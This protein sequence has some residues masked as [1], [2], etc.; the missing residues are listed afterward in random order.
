[1]GQHFSRASFLVLA[2]SLLGG[3]ATRPI[4]PPIAEVELK[5]GYRYLTH[6]A[7]R[8]NNDSRTL[9]I[10]AFSGGGTRAA[11]F[12]Y[13]V[14]EALR[15][16]EVIGPKGRKIRLLDE[17]DVVTGVSG[18]SFTALA[19]GLYGEKLF[20]LYE[21]SFLKRD[22]QGELV[23]R[24]FNPGNWGALWSEGWGRSEMAAQLYDEILFHGATFADLDRGSGPLVLASATDI[25]TGERLVFQQL[26]F[27]YLCSDLDAVPLSRAAA[28]SSA[29]P[30]ALSP[31]TL[32][33]YGGS[34]K[35]ATSPWGRVFAD[36]A[37]APRPAA[38]AIKHLQ[39]M[40]AYQ[41]GRH[42]PYIHLVDG[43]L[44]DNLGMRGVL[45]ALEELEALKLMGQPTPLDHVQ[46]I[47]VFIVDSLS[48]PQTNWDESARPPSDVAILIKATGVPIDHYSYEATELLKDTMARWQT[49][50]RIRAS[51]AF[52]SSEDPAVAQLVNAPNVDLYAIDVSFSALDDPAEVEYLNNLPTSFVLP[53]E[54][55]DRLRSAAGAIIRSSPEF[56]R[57][58]KDAGAELV[59]QPAEAKEPVTPP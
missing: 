15:G 22:V 55:V 19:Y 45:E 9:V 27:D 35:F 53:P 41:D 13:G 48:S 5:H 24:F 38:R 21:T 34:C 36:P 10:L 26:D 46:R 32:N 57:L 56:K 58:L 17:V 43:G 4:N 33:N 18:G 52:T 8:P 54:A 23:A 42:K 3:C 31:V 49:M 51:A 47:V 7:H 6:E 40:Q 44:A 29:V 28:A 25:S 1:M 39:E 37:T 30:F 20:D 16:M 2:V 59:T 50:R 11:A 14:L 12:S